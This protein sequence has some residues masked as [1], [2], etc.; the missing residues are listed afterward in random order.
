M[1]YKYACVVRGACV[2]ACMNVYDICMYQKQQFQLITIFLFFYHFIVNINISI[3]C[4]CFI[5][6]IIQY[7]LKWHRQDQWIRS[8]TCKEFSFTYS[9]RER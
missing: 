6:I 4:C 8:K 3:I 5:I 9:F 1:K 7:Y 2:R